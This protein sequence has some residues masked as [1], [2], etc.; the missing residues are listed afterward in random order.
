MSQQSLIGKQIDEYKLETMLGEGGMASVYRALDVR[1][2][3]YVA[4]KVI[5]ASFRADSDYTMRFEREAQAIAQLEHPSI[6]T[7]HRFGEL[8]NILYM[9][10]QYVDGADLAAVIESYHGDGVFIEF[11]EIIKLAHEIGAALDYAHSKGVIHRDIKPHNILINQ[12]GRAIVSDFGLALMTEVGTRGEIF[13]SPHY[14]APEQAISSAGVVPQSDL[15]ALAVILYEMLTGVVPFDADEPLDIAMKHMSEEPPSPRAL[16][17]EL[18]QEVEDVL[19]KALSKRPEDRYPSGKEL[20]VALENAIKAKPSTQP[21]RKSQYT[22]PQRVALELEANPLPPIPDPIMRTTKPHEAPI[23][24]ATAVSTQETVA[25]S[26]QDKEK[27]NGLPIAGMLVG[28]LTVIA[29]IAGLLF[30]LNRN[31]NG[32]IETATATQLVEIASDENTESATTTDVTN[33]ATQS[34]SATPRPT[35]EPTVPNTE[36][37]V[38]I[39]PTNTIP[40]TEVPAVQSWTLDIRWVGEDSLFILND[41]TSDFPLSSL[42][43]SGGGSVSGSEW[44]V[45]M[46]APGQCVGVFKDSGNPQS[47]NTTCELIGARLT[48]TG[49][50][51]F[52]KASFAVNYNGFRVTVCQASPCIVEISP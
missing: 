9:V 29:L 40:P 48:R 10:M 11:D 42:D 18:S 1:L 41:S 27:R 19:L 4:V 8:D 36:A 33:T 34:P 7:I 51:R 2:N 14:I 52:W 38:V 50:D 17:P 43:L 45:E 35:L 21:K 20:A 23:T 24:Q 13:G 30:L 28:G 37:P 47:A 3:R 44:A 16:R 6:I 49:P 12:D 15:Y 5:R 46:L 32:S 22:I 39:P 26:R 25:A 31:N